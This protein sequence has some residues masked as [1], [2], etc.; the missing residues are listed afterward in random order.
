MSPAILNLC[1]CC[2]GDCAKV[3]GYDPHLGALCAD[4]Y[5]GM[6]AGQGALAATGI[7]GV[8]AG[9]CGDNRGTDLKGDKQ[10]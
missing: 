8:F 7:K 9:D 4:C 2:L 3:K 6:M 10:P 5:D 1:Q